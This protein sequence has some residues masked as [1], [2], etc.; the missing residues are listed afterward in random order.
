MATRDG[1]LVID[2]DGHVMEPLDLWSMRMDEA[3]WGDWIPHSD[4]E[5]GRF[6]VGG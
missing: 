6:W 3:R 2:G 1:E 4:P 5:T